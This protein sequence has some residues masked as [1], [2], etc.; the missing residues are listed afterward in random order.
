[1]GS[2]DRF[3]SLCVDLNYVG[4]HMAKGYEALLNWSTRMMEANFLNIVLLIS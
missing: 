1:M 2:D 4:T 3:G